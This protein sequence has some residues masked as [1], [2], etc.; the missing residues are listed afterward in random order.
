MGFLIQRIDH[1]QVAAPKG[2]EETARAF[3]SG[4]LGMEEVEK[5]DVLKARGGAW[6]KSGNCHLHVGIEEPFIPA[7]KAHPAFAVEGYE[8]LREHLASKSV[9]FQDDNDIPGVV[10]MYVFDPFGNRIELMKNKQ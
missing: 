5:P 8:E 4:V 7:K 10:R 3:Y 2:E 1:V 9:R 6:F